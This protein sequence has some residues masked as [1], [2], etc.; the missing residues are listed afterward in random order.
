MPIIEMKHEGF[1][2]LMLACLLAFIEEKY[3]RQ[4]NMAFVNSGKFFQYFAMS[5]KVLHN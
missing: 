3:V 1:I 4:I 2:C 5:L